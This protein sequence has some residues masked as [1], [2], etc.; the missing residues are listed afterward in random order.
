MPLTAE[1]RRRVDA[2]L[3]IVRERTFQPLATLAVEG[4]VTPEQLSAAAA[5]NG[6]FAPLEPGT[7]WGGYGRYLWLRGRFTL[8]PESADQRIVLRIGGDADCLVWVNGDLAGSHGWAASPITLAA[9][10]QPGATYDLLIEASAGYGNDTWWKVL[11]RGPRYRGDPGELADRPPTHAVTPPTVGIWHDDLYA[12]AIDLQTLLELRDGLPAGSLRQATIDRG[13]MDAT[14]IADPEAEVPAL[15]AS[16][17][18]ARE[19]LHPLLAHHNGPTAPTLYMIGHGHLDIAWL[20]PLA[21][22]QRKIARTLIN[23]LNLFA[24]YPEHRFLQSQPYLYAMLRSHYPELYERAMEAVRAGQIIPDG[25][26]YVEA[27]TNLSG[28]EALIRQFLRGRAFFRDELGVE[29]DLLWLPDVFGYSGALPQIMRGC[30]VPYFATQKI[31]WAYGGSETFP[32]T[33]FR[34][35]GIDGSIVTAHIFSQYGS[36]TRPAELFARWNTRLQADAEI[37]AMIVAYGWGDGGGGP[38]RDHLEF[39]R[40][41]ADLEGLPRTR[42]A[43]PRAFFADLERN[44]PP[45]AH[46]IGE[47]Y[48]QAHRGTYTSQAR[49]KAFNRRCEFALRAAELWG[50]AAR[51][52]AGFNFTPHTLADAWETVLLN[53]FHDI[54]PGSSINRVYGEAEAA[55]AAALAQARQS[56]CA[57]AVSLTD[58]D[59]QAL[60]VFNSLSR[61]RRELIPLPAGWPGAA[62]E[63]ATLPVQVIDGVLHADVP[64]PP[65][66][67]ITLVS[68][69]PAAASSAVRLTPLP[70]GSVELENSRVK[71]VLNARGELT[72]LI[73]KTNGL[74]TLS[75]PGNSFR[76][77]KDV[78]IWFDAWDIDRMAEQQPVAIDEPVTLEV[79]DAGPLVARIRLR[80]AL[81]ASTVEQVI[82][83][84]ADS[85]RIDF[86]TTIDWRE[87]HRLL[88]VAFPTNM[89]A[90]E[91]LHEIQFGH[92]A[93]PNHRSR[94]FDAD[95][96]EV[97]AHKWSALAEAGRGAAVLND[98]KYGIS[99]LGG[100]LSLTLLKAA[101]APDEQADQGVQQFT[102]AFCVW[103][104]GLLTGGFVDEAYALNESPLSVPGA[105]A[106]ARHSL[107][108]VDAPNI[109]LETVKP[110][111]DG[112]PDL[113]VR[114]YE[115]ARSRTRCTLTLGIACAAAAET[116]MLETSLGELPIADGRIDLMFRPFEIKTLRLSPGGQ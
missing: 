17:A 64:L 37:D 44:G 94:P 2:W 32:Y 65:C 4:F 55:Y 85:A 93:R 33:T 23:Q 36:E 90:N 61:S 9:A 88:K 34:W 106:P 75:A 50:C 3:S 18:A 104:G 112:S 16:A 86:A 35:E 56:A 10:G 116:D 24:E 25:G 72:S 43:P 91:A 101:L 108:A 31:T 59:A 41:A 92:L 68:A 100:T 13:L 115:A 73:D 62:A 60:T 71:G 39:L 102:Y 96:F 99:V 5:C 49:T 87:R 79:L 58:G 22:T 21:E 29:S 46:H 77:Y 83:L 7:P 78:P 82:S 38:N 27:D 51:A 19:R 74:E 97:C 63:G 76:L 89:H 69:P 103:N 81:S 30:G 98:S 15:R 1:W 95:R 14:L 113:I 11:S 45:T 84:R 47:I 8:P 70:G 48:F 111:E 53:Q 20:W 40:R 107:F 80:R 105:A 54:L 110:A 66:G 28:G 52:L 67:W 12:L 109:V 26:M 6:P 42:I 114:L 57:A